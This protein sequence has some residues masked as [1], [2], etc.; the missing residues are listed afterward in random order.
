LVLLVTPGGFGS[1]AV[2]HF[3]ERQLHCSKPRIRRLNQSPLRCQSGHSD[4]LSS[5]SQTLDVN[6]ALI[7]HEILRATDFATPGCRSEGSVGQSRT[8]RVI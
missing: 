2:L 8:C 4:E 5:R 6:M 7:W 3:R 1:T